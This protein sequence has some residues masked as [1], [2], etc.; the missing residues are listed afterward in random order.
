VDDAEGVD[1]GVGELAG[2][3]QSI[4]VVELRQD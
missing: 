2:L 4:E 1:G 3:R